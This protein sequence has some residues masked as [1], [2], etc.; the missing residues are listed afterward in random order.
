MFRGGNLRLPPHSSFLSY[1]I[2]RRAAMLN[3]GKKTVQRPCACPAAPSAQFFSAG[4]ITERYFRNNDK[5]SCGMP[6]IHGRHAAA[7]QL[8]PSINRSG[9]C[10][11]PASFSFSL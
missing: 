3:F 2:P 6:A 10:V 5:T 11:C 9:S 4:N 1:H 8:I 7:A